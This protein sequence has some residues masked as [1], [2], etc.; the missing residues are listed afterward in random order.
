MRTV[1][2]TGSTRGIGFGLAECFLRLGQ[3]VL[4][5]GRSKDNLDRALEK[6]SGTFSETRLAGCACDVRD[7]HQL[8]ALWDCGVEHFGRVDIWINNA[9]VGQGA[10]PFWDQDQESIQEIISVNLLGL[11]YGAQV[12]L[13]GFLAQGS[14]ALY[15][16]E[17]LG[18]EGRQIPGLAVY[19]STKRGVGYLT[20]ALSQEV[21]DSGVI[22]G[23]LS[24]GMVLT[25]LLLKRYRGMDPADWEDT[26]RIFNIL[27]DRVDTV[28]PYLADRILAN[29]KNGVRI[30][31]LTPAKVLWRFLTAPLTGR[32]LFRDLEMEQEDH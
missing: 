22:V 13:K 14:G 12:A 8:R 29:H 28:A 32:E 10:Q 16:M 4:I 27:A 26:R 18:S 7:H 30:A 6:L 25:D 2:I 3:Q 11:A 24:P 31:W 20:R 1:I 5:S 15:N 19:G 9:G 23:S 21:Q 17:G